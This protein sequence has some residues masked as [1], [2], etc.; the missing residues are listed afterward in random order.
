VTH[1]DSSLPSK[2]GDELLGGPLCL[3]T[4]LVEATGQRRRAG[5]ARRDSRLDSPSIVPFTSSAN[6]VL[7]LSRRVHR[8]LEE[9]THELIDAAISAFLGERKESAKSFAAWRY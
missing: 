7:P 8:L 3:R 4:H 2:L 5:L 1:V 6:R 9:S